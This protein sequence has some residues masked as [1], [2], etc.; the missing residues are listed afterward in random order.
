MS[1]NKKDRRNGDYRVAAHSANAFL[2]SSVTIF[3]TFGETEKEVSL[4]A[5][6]KPGDLICAATNLNL[7]TELYIKS[8]LIALNLTVPEH[9]DLLKLYQAIPDEIKSHLQNHYKANE[10]YK[11]RDPIY[12]YLQQSRMGAKTPEPPIKII[13]KTSIEDVLGRAAKGFILWRYTH[14]MCPPGTDHRSLLIEFDRLILICKCIE[15]FIVNNDALFHSNI[16][17]PI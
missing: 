2:R 11:D 9:H 14:E 10:K 5:A 12:T 3:E 16:K 17:P 1:A 8:L 6:K 7:A 4:N 13:T 15:I